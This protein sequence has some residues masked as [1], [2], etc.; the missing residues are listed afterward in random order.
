LTILDSIGDGL[1]VVDGKM[2][3]VLMNQ[4]AVEIVGY[5]P[6]ALSRD[7]LQKLYTAF[8]PDGLTTISEDNQPLERSIRERR[9]VEAELLLKGQGLPWDGLMVRVKAAAIFDDKGEFIG[10]VSVFH[11]ISERQRLLRQRD[12]LAGLITHDLKNHL[13]AESAVAE[14]L[15]DE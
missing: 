4:A 1:L 9:P 8:T 5:N 11:D 13:A 2:K 12:T 15:M 10:G 3:L 14:L 7:E 6:G